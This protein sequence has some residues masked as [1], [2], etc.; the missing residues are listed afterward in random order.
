MP[1]ATDATTTTRLPER[2]RTFLAAPRYATISTVNPD[3]S[4]HQAIVWY[5]LDGDNLLIN[6]RAERQWPTN[7]RRDPRISI[8][9][10]EVERPFHWIGLK[11][12]ADLVNE[13]DDATNDVMALARRYSKD[14]NAYKGQNRLT[15]RVRVE[16]T[17][18]YGADD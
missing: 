1:K 8:A 9:V 18:E 13:G 14:P 3:G 4:P 16:Q 12:R 7:L 15:F 5:A 10:Y 2:I 11:G 6:S 17:Y